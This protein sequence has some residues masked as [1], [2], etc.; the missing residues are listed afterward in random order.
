M[1]L[2]VNHVLGERQDGHH[3]FAGLRLCTF[4]LQ[5]YV[6]SVLRH[7]YTAQEMLASCYHNWGYLRRC[8]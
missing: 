8:N 5:Q 1:Q 6:L 3:N 7:G 2:I 4:G